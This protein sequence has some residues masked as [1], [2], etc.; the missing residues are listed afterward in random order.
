MAKI[1]VTV[2][3]TMQAVV[4]Q[5]ENVRT[6]RGL[7]NPFRCGSAAM[8]QRNGARQ[9][10]SKRLPTIW[11]EFSH[12]WSLPLPSRLDYALLLTGGAASALGVASSW[13]AT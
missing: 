4:V 7:R 10:P 12:K 13:A 8:L 3:T 11:S 1:V 2:A 5:N 9:L 6:T